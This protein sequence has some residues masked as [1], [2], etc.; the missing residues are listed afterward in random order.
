MIELKNVEKVYQTKEIETLALNRINLKISKGEFA[1]IR[2]LW[3]RK[4]HLTQCDRA[5]RCAIPWRDVHQRR[6]CAKPQR[7]ESCAV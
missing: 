7:E 4:K 2:P 1:S 6:G 3:M 5:A